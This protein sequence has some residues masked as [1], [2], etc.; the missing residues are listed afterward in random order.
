MSVSPIWN[1]LSEEDKTKIKDFY[2]NRD[3]ASTELDFLPAMAYKTHQPYPLPKYVEGDLTEIAVLKSNGEI[4]LDAPNVV[5]FPCAKVV[6]D[7]NTDTYTK[8]VIY[9][10]K[11]VEFKYKLTVK[12]KGTDNEEVTRITLPSGE[13]IDFEGWDV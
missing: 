10:G 6:W 11:T 13:Y 8:T 1:N 7:K 2:E 4:R 3:T 5:V 9:D 12:N